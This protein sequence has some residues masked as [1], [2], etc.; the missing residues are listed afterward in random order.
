MALNALHRWRPRQNVAASGIVEEYASRLQRYLA[1]GALALD[2]S[3][4]AQ[5]LDS[6]HGANRK[7][8]FNHGDL[9]LSNCM[10]NRGCMTLIDWEFSGYYLPGYDLALLWLLLAND[11]GARTQVEQQVINRAPDYRQSFAINRFLLIGRE[12]RIHSALQ[13]SDHRT[14][15]LDQLGQDL[16]TAWVGFA[17]NNK[18]AAEKAT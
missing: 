5:I 11:Q 13:L 14:Q 15:R 8:E 12:T 4:M 17:A 1:S 9:L 18:A 6:L 2:P 16:Q 7:F 10:L 3:Q